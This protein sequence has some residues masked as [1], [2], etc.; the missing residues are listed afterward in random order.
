MARGVSTVL[1]VAVCLLLVGAAIAT[2]AAA[3]P[4]STD[5]APDADVPARTVS[6]ATVGVPVDDRTRH[7]TLAAHLGSVAVTGAT[8]DGQR[9]LDTSYPTAVAN[10]TDDA[11][12]NR[13][14]VTATWEPY[15]NATVGG[16]LTAGERPPE[17]ADVA[18]STLAVDTG[19]EVRPPDGET[20]FETLSRALA[21]AYVEWLF[22]PE[23]TRAALVDQRTAPG[24]V[25]R[26]RSVGDALGVD[27]DPAVDDANVEAANEALAAEL[28][29]RF[30]A[31]LRARYE[32]PDAA[33]SELTADE[34]R[35]VVRRW[36]HG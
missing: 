14:F 30:E 26:Y 18:A 27:V 17:S 28:A 36:K 31:E 16:R 23:R 20:S 22:P 11:V 24:T 25:A 21:T 2:L 5:S 4:S 29:S 10:A 32:S 19:I 7:G 15:P 1:D 33:A 34:S 9:L 3:P 13:V 6:T 8:L 12:D 35:I